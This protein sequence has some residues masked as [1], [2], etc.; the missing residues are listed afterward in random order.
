MNNA[1]L[2]RNINSEPAGVTSDEVVND[3]TVTGT[4]VSDALEALDLKTVR[5][6]VDAVET[7]GLRMW[8]GSVLTDASGDFSFDISPAGF[9]TLLNAQVTG[10]RNTAV[11]T[12]VVLASIATQSTTTITGSLVTGD[13]LGALGPTLIKAPIGTTVNLVAFGI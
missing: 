8:M 3:S 5:T 4:T 12:D 2:Q 13:I 11:A 7:T 1:H 9:T 10:V 6:W